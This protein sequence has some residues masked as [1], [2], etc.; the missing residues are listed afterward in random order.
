[1]PLPAHSMPRGQSQS[2]ARRR[3]HGP[4]FCPPNRAC[5]RVQVAARLA[6]THALNSPP[7][8]NAPFTAAALLCEHC[9]NHMALSITRWSNDQLARASKHT[10]CGRARAVRSA[11]GQPPCACEMISHNCANK[12]YQGMQPPCMQRPP[13]CG[14]G[15]PRSRAG[16]YRARRWVRGR[17]GARRAAQCCGGRRARRVWQGELC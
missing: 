15:T 7:R 9:C 6:A 10:A 14:W 3:P 2:H 5:H 4:P 12:A 1:M 17:E 8:R 11:Q 16:G 13:C